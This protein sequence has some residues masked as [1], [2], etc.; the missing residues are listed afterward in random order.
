M[1]LILLHSGSSA[2]KENKNNL[3]FKVDKKRA[4]ND[5]L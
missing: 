2:L 4:S 1:F 3:A 5:A